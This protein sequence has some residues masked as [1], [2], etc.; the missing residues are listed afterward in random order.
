MKSSEKKI[1]SQFKDINYKFV[2]FIKIY[3]EKNKAGYQNIIT[4]GKIK[5]K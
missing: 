4:L 2:N 3:L 5:K 1:A